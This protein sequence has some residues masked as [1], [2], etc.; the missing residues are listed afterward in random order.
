M[1]ARTEVISASN[2][3]A[4]EAIVQADVGGQ[5]EWIATRDNRTRETHWNLDGEAVGI[6]E[7]FSNGLEYP[8]D[9]SGEPGEIINCR[10]T[11]GWLDEGEEPS[12]QPGMENEPYPD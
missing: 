6:N 3:G 7:K 12:Q 4:Y 10:C 11:I 8:G 9:P 1:I 5:K 2:Y